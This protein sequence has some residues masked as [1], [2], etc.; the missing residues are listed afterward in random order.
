[1]VK[2]ELYEYTLN[3]EENEQSLKMAIKDNNIYFALENNHG[4]TY[5]VFIALSQIK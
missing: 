3:T 4:E 5:S 1:M 2:N